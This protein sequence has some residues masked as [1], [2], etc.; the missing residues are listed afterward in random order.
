M[1]G[2]VSY[3]LAEPSPQD[4]SLPGVEFIC[5]CPDAFKGDLCELNKDEC[6]KD[7]CNGADVGGK[8]VDTIGSFKCECNPG[9]VGDT[10]SE[11]Q[12]L[13]DF[14]PNICGFGMN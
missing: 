5:T 7:M 4:L 14:V 10:C 11:V 9:F 3:A 6:E 1:N 8:C 2:G 12:T 13:C